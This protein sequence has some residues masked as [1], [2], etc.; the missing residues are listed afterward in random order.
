M[1][2]AEAPHSRAGLPLTPQPPCPPIARPLEEAGPRGAARRNVR[3]GAEGDSNRESSVCTVT[4]HRGRTTRLSA[5]DA[6]RTG[7]GAAPW[8]LSS[9]RL[10]ALY[11]R[12]HAS[13]T[14]I[15]PDLCTV[16]NHLRSGQIAG[17]LPQPRGYCEES[18]SRETRK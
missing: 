7:K 4:W 8:P 6:A 16:M 1:T 12:S 3:G 2:R 9:L 18:V 13:L 11:R 5:N 10:A 14:E 17:S 15:P